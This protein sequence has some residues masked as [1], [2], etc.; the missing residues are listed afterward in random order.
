MHVETI[1]RDD[2]VVL[3]PGGPVDA[4]VI[5]LHG[6]GADGFDFVPVAEAL[7]LPRGHGVRFIFPHAPQRPVTI[8]G[9]LPMRAWYDIYGLAEGSGEDTAG[10]RA[11]AQLVG[12][13]I[14]AQAAEGVA[15]ER[16]VV[17]GFSQGGAIT[18][19]AG[20]RYPYR[21]AGLIALSTYLPM[22]A[23]LADEAC[24]ANADLPLLI[25]HGRLD[26]IVPYQWGV[27]TRDELMRRG[28]PV[29]WAAYPMQHE[30]CAEEVAL[31]SDWLRQRLGY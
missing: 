25:A 28:H 1:A 22:H 21:L 13:Y 15:R 29:E 12:R 10:I 2:A 4:T 19:H 16:I 18:L 9:G 27:N 5:W 20:L 24:E 26:P 8:N 31:I 14:E 7:H 11:S 6:L 3:E 23:T 17:A 30:V